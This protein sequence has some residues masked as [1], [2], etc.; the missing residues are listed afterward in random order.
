MGIQQGLL[1]ENTKWYKESW[2][3]EEVIENENCKLS[4]D[5]EYHLPKT[6]TAR[7]PDVIIELK[8][9]KK[10]YLVDMACPN[11]GNVNAKHLEKIQKY[12]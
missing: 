6:T 4:W 10:I 3:K 5:F 1:E 2:N 9:E 12:Q 8:K 11:E 7:R